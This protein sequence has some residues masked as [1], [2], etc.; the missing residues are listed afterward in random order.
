[1][2]GNRILCFAGLQTN[3]AWKISVCMACTVPGCLAVPMELGLATALP[4]LGKLPRKRGLPMKRRAASPTVNPQALETA[5]DAGS[6]E[7]LPHPL[8]SSLQ[9]GQVFMSPGHS[10]E[11]L[12][13][14][15][16][17]YAEGYMGYGTGDSI[18]VIPQCP[19]SCGRG[20]CA[21][22]GLC[23]LPGVPPSRLLSQAPGGTDSLLCPFFL[24]WETYTCNCCQPY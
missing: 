16:W 23:P 1:M 4:V 22:P 18:Q 13:M 17:L 5:S 9:V 10:Q 6:A 24:S 14:R 20:D 2:T 8:P 12:R 21:K 19:Q 3:A 15:C 11:I 7:R